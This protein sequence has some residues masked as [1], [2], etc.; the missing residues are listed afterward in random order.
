MVQRLTSPGVSVTEVDLTTIVPSLATSVGAFAGVFGWG[1]IGERILVSSESDLVAKFTAPTSHNPETFFTAANFLGY[2]NSL[3]ISRAANT[4][5]ATPAVTF[6]SNTSGNN[7][8]LYASNTSG[9]VAGMYI[10]QSPNPLIST[11]LS[12]NVVSVNSSSITLSKYYGASSNS[13]VPL[14][15]AYPRTSYSAIGFEP[16]AVCSNLVNQIVT[17][18]QQYNAVKMNTFENGVTWLAK[19]P[20]AIGNSLRVAQCDT[21]NQFSSNVALSNTIVTGTMATSIGSNTIAFSFLNDGSLGSNASFAT[22]VLNQISLGDQVRVGNSSISIQF[23]QVGSVSPISVNSSVSSFTVGSFD[24]YRLRTPYTA[25]TMTRQWEFFNEVSTA[26]GQSTWQ[27]LNGNTAAYDQMH[28]VVVDD[29]GDFTGTPGSI[30]EV[31]KNLSRATDNFN[32][33]GTSNYYVNVINKGSKYIWWGADRPNAYSDTSTNLTNATTSSPGDYKFTLGSDGASESTASLAEIGQAYDLFASKE[34]VLI[35]LV[36]QGKPI[37]GT[38]VVSSQTIQN[39]QLAQYIAESIVGQRLDCV[40]FISPDPALVLNNFGQEA[41]SIVNWRNALDSSSYMIMD[42]GY[43]YQYDRYNDVYRWIPMNGDI[44]GLCARTDS[45]RAPWWSPAGLNRGQ[46][47]NVI[48]LAYNPKQADRDLLYAHGINS[49]VSFPGNGVILNGDK[50]LQTKPSAFDRINV[51]RLF[52]TIERAISL[53]AKYSLFEFNDTF[54]RAQFVALITP[55]LRQIQ[56]DRGIYDFLVICDA[57]NNPGNVVD[58]NAM[59]CSIFIKPA[60]SINFINLSFVATSTSVQF[61]T[62][63][64]KF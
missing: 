9:I 46:I 33:D 28:V 31:Y 38:T 35:D 36:M 48:K 17:N 23:M 62:V 60:R 5:G 24:P 7:N 16:N 30:L 63:V 37:G 19:Y 54:T 10:T 3:Y 61:S 51:R 34:D 40:G 39:Y 41:T 49:V 53:S 55:Y 20:G 50:T 26:P 15:F 21:S 52:L 58:E 59:N 4:T 56:G 32:N 22:T 11:G 12:S 14:Y 45:I 18:S 1:P 6:Q 44:A 2:T 42:T 8:V 64:G 13:T 27:E 57:T 47:N 43:K 29:G 25:N